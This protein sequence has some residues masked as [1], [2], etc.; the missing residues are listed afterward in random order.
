ML[1]LLPPLTNRISE[2]VR[3]TLDHVSLEHTPAYKTWDQQAD[4]NLRLWKRYRA[5]ATHVGEKLDKEK[6]WFEQLKRFEWGEYIALS[7]TWGPSDPP[8]Y[9]ILNGRY[10]PVSQ[11]LE[12][13]LRAARVGWDQKLVLWV[14]AL[15]INQ[16]NLG[17][18][19]V[20]VQRMRELY[21][22]AAWIIIHLGAESNDLGMRTIRTVA[23]KI[24]KGFDWR[25]DSFRIATSTKE[26]EPNS[27]RDALIAAFKVFTLSY[28]SR[29]WIIQELAMAQDYTCCSGN[30]WVSL[31]DIRQVMKLFVLN[32]DSLIAL[33]PE[34]YLTNNV[35]EF[36]ST[37]GILWWIGRVRELTMLTPDREHF[38]YAEIR[39]PILSLAQSANATDA[40]DKVYGLLG[41]LPN[42]ISTMMDL[43]SKNYTIS[44]HDL[45]LKV[46]I[47]ISVSFFSRWT[48]K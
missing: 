40:R 6:D 41:L 13:A 38:T 43:K 30:E 19:G 23:D 46:C 27:E 32:T 12:A 42:K 31:A 5:W 1:K 22:G 20:Q 33:L 10:F 45:F 9:I 28:W 34:D 24:K 35:A 44:T 36:Q 3:V 8:C 37:V 18:R 2:P 25:E 16:S 39:S 29:M 4:P 15:C 7:Y 17:E 48:R 26:G 47:L 11:N 21:G 14:D